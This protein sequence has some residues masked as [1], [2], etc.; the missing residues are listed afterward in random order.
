MW[1]CLCILRLSTRWTPDKVAEVES[2]LKSG[3]HPR[4]VKMSLAWEITSSFYGDAAADAAAENFRTIF[5]K[6]EHPRR[7]ADN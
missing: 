4:D 5:Q 6:G 1:R 2:S 7:C 3:A